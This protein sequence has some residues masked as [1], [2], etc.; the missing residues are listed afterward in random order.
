M[1]YPVPDLYLTLFG[2]LFPRISRQTHVS[3][4][5]PSVVVFVCHFPTPNLPDTETLIHEPTP[6][7]SRPLQPQRAP[8]KPQRIPRKRA[9]KSG[10][11]KTNQT[12]RLQHTRKCRQD[13]SSISM[14]FLRCAPVSLV[15][16]P[17]ASPLTSPMLPLSEPK[18][19]ASQSTLVPAAP[20][21][22]GNRFFFGTGR[23]SHSP[24][25]PPVGAWGP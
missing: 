13:T 16:P 14:P 6:P 1:E 2:L 12:H 24:K 22:Q 10:D 25:Q 20:S 8:K 7:P 9:L 5:A 4:I 11:N 3:L 19:A 15:R 23:Q 21:V 17:V 18:H